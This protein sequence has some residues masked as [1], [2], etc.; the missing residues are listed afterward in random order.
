MNLLLLL[1]ITTT[2]LHTLVWGVVQTQQ[3]P[4]RG[5]LTNIGEGLGR[6]YKGLKAGDN[7]KL[8]VADAL[9]GDFDR[10]AVLSEALLVSQSHPI[11]LF[12]WDASPACKKAL[13]LLDLAQVKPHIVRLDSPWD[14]GNQIR[15]VLGRLNGGKTSVPIIYIGGKYV[16]GCDDGV[17]E[18][19]PGL[20]PLAFLNRLS[21]ALSA[22]GAFTPSAA[23]PPITVLKELAV[24]PTRRPLQR[25]HSPPAPAASL[26]LDECPSDAQCELD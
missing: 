8:A 7:F 4:R 20:V 11:V 16:G 10:E 17:T 5:L 19:A 21:P 23:E 26:L 25:D 13:K 2:L 14:K 15:A 12:T 6:I 22:A 24:E 1:T 9:A 18:A 3:T